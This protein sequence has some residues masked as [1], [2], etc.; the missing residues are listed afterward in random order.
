MQ[1]DV[2]RNVLARRDSLVLMPTGGGKSI[3][4]QLPAV[5]LDGVT[6]VVSPLIALMK[7]Q[8]DA[9][10][11]KGVRAAFV[12]STMTDAEIRNVQL[13]AYRGDLDILYVAPERIFL[14]RFKD[15]LHAMKL[16]LIAIDEAHCISEW[17]HDFRPDYRNLRQL[18]SDFPDTPIIALTATATER[19]RE[20]IVHHMAMA[21]AP[22]FIASFNR[23]NLSYVVTPKDKSFDTLVSL[24]R[25]HRGGSAIIYRFSRQ[26]TE[27]LAAK[28]RGR[29]FSALPY[30]AGL[31][32]DVRRR[33]QERFLS[34]E[35]PIVV[36][37]IA[38]GMGVDKPNI[39][40]VVH[41]DLP[42]TIEGYYQETGRAGR[43][44]LPSECVLFFSYGDR[45]K[46][47]YFINQI[48]DRARRDHAAQQLAKMVEYAYSHTCRRAFLLGYFGE[49]WDESDCGG[50]DVCQYVPA[51]DA[52]M[53][54]GTEI[55][56]KILS[57][58]I[59]TR[60]RFG[61]AH[62]VNVLRGSRSQRVL[63]LGHDRLSV[64]GI[65]RD[66]SKDALLDYVEQLIRQ[67]LVERNPGE[68]PTLAVTTQGRQF[69]KNRDTLKLARAEGHARRPAATR[70][71][72]AATD[73]DTAL[74][75]KLRAL[76]RRLADEAGVPAYVVFG[77]AVLRQLAASMPRD[78]AAMLSIKG[79]GERK[80]TMYGD[81]FLAA[82]TEH[83]A[84]GS[85]DSGVP[86]RAPIYE[87]WTTEDEQELEALFK[88]GQPVNEIAS[89]LGRS[90][91]AV[92]SRLV[93]LGLVAQG[94][95]THLLTL[96]LVRGGMNVA[97]I[98]QQRGISQETVLTHL[99]R[100]ADEDNATDLAHL[101]PEPRRYQQIARAF[102][103]SETDRLRPVMEVLGE[104]YSYVELRLVRLGMCRGG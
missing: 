44:G 84:N 60:E 68:F 53:F 61:A 51:N 85:S 5:V 45:I 80:L 55:A 97:E 26:D 15:F 23:P 95:E 72:T 92:R 62:V 3:C 56:Q 64:H 54:D 67:G 75:D 7:D 59:R 18:R 74:F 91:G 17:G 32:D 46:Q 98:A 8:V 21:D 99:E 86:S 48:E 10:R 50:C 103:T 104:G 35:V 81:S 1:E 41:Y 25:K 12:N 2:V 83:A 101:M 47:Q 73:Y 22:R 82:I 4:Y 24:L 14:R 9:L 102:A 37:T 69:L 78:R 30:H 77:D 90:H 20:D 96:E 71:D 43:D 57:A 36:A 66:M 100:L 76:R 40:L 31:E 58:V 87:Y 93:R 52:D 19:V 27:D 94:G 39:R 28:L 89:S 79:V 34:D 6:L 16:S 70:G 63:N 49:K 38:F 88:S 13:E 29:G 11:T 33:T 65:A 42:K